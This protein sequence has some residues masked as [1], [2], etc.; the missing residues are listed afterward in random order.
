M[1]DVEALAHDSLQ[2][3]AAGSEGGATARHH[4]TARLEA[5]GFR[6]AADSF[7]V[8]RRTGEPLT[9]VNLRVAVPG[10]EHPDRWLV[11]T[12]HYDHVGVRD[13]EV[14]NGAD[15][16]ASGTAALL[17]L[18]AALS[19][20]PPRHGVLLAF[21]DAEEGGLQGARHLVA[22]PPVPLD[23]V[24]LNVNLDMVGHAEGEL[25]VAGTT[26]YPALRPLV[27]AVA[28]TP[29][30]FLAFGHDTEADTGSDNWINASDHAAFHAQG[31]PFLYFGVADHP[32]YHR[33]TDD[34]ATL[35]PA[36]LAGATATVLEVVRHLDGVL[37]GERP[38][39]RPD[40]AG[41]T[42]DGA[43]VAE[44]PGD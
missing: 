7:P 19:R 29:P 25:W 40:A 1:A 34:P 22:E 38:G 8:R 35:N 12:A 30:V 24:L 26:P 32:D 44:T 15:D 16:N 6:V 2:G 18:A 39:G 33:P 21:L 28:P 9:G 4:L 41:M 11:L 42:D 36:F 37:A 43:G 3:R 10:T 23:A 31:I 5:L 17:A 14:Y 20:E 13:G 27:E